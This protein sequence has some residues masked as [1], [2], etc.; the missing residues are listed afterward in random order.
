M[1]TSFA[2]ETLEVVLF[3]HY[4]EYLMYPRLVCKVEIRT[5]CD[6]FHSQSCTQKEI[7][8]S[9]PV[10]IKQGMCKMVTNM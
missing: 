7:H 6:Q 2:K 3:V 4:L 5:T 1:M 8:L 9:N 10:L